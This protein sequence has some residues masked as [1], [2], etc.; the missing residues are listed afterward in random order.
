M[1]T[2]FSYLKEFWLNEKANKFLIVLGLFLIISLG[3]NY[4]L[5]FKIKYIKYFST[6]NLKFLKIFAF[7]LLPVIFSFVS[8]ALLAK[9]KVGCSKKYLLFDYKIWIFIFISVS[10]YSVSVCFTPYSAYIKDNFPRN[11]RSFLWQSSS[12]I[13]RSTLMIALP[14]LYFLFTKKRGDRF[15]GFHISKSGMQIYLI[16]AIVA[17]IGV[18]VASFGESFAKFYPM[19]KPRGELNYFNI[20]KLQAYGIYETIYGL[21]FVSVEF[22]FRG[23]FV[24][25]LARLMGQGAIY[26]MA[27]L[28][29][30]IH[31]SKPLAESVSSFFGGMLLGIIAYRTK[32]IYGGIILHLTLAIGMDLFALAQKSW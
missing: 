25:A 10:I 20:T 5:N 24:F 16:L 27:S 32:S 1:K 31:F 2:I 22:F 9:D 12:L 18:F 21:S 29:M 6:G 3:V 4:S 30:Y 23:F 11:T 15:Y 14:Y 13:L 19:Y 8:Y 17:L 26:V 28:Y 7:F